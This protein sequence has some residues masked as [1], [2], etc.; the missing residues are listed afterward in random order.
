MSQNSGSVCV[1]CRRENLKLFLKGDRC[2]GEKCSFD[3][4]SYPPGQHGQRRTKFS[5]FAVQL[6]EKQKVKKLYSLNE[7]Q[8]RGYV[9]RAEKEKGI[10]GER[11]L[12]F[13]ESRFDD[14]VYKIGFASSRAQARQLIG[15][16]HFSVNGKRVHS[17]SYQLQEGDVIEVKEKS[18]K[19]VPVLAALDSVK[20]R[21]I[22]EWLELDAENYKGTVKRLP[23][24]DDITVP[25]QENLIVEYYS[26]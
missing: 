11:L 26:R 20:R 18:R 10:T 22:P 25:I 1:H 4:R 6:R 8:F 5:E 24:R 16:K 15:H 2:Y 23:A 9:K 7:E 13:L 17:P 19:I 3:R 14:V 12:T 21:E